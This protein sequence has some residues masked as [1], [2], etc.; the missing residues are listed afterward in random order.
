M[1]VSM[2]RF[3]TAMARIVTTAVDA[4]AITKVGCSRAKP[5]ASVRSSGGHP[6]ITSRSYVRGRRESI[7][8]TWSALSAECQARGLTDATSDFAGSRPADGASANF[9]PGRRWPKLMPVGTEGPTSHPARRSGILA[10][11]AS[12]SCPDAGLLHRRS[13]GQPRDATGCSTGRREMRSQQRTRWGFDSD[14][15]PRLETRRAVAALQRALDAERALADAA[16]T[17]PEADVPNGSREL[18]LVGAGG[19]DLR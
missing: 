15:D 4:P 1:A 14:D 3:D 19:R 18:E 16:P 10:N 8:S 11:A 7:R 6:P 13:G 5:R 2:C 9:R 12:H 17:T